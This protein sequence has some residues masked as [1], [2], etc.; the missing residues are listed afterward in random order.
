MHLNYLWHLRQ[1]LKRCLNRFEPSQYTEQEW[2]AISVPTFLRSCFRG[3]VFIDNQNMQPMNA[4]QNLL[5]IYIFIHL[6]LMYISAYFH[7][8]VIT[9]WNA[10]FIYIYL[11]IYFKKMK[12]ICCWKVTYAFVYICN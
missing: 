11:S 6:Q 2:K 12:F 7:A 1:N 3:T 8:I 5:C 9:L 4:F 10:K